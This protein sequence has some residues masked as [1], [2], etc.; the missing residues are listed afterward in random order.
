MDKV[1]GVIGGMGPL[2]A[3][4]LFE[5]IVLLTDAHC[6]QEH[7]HIIIDN[8]TTIP[9]RTDYI[10]GVIPDD[11]KEGLIDSAKKLQSIGADF[12]VICCNTAHYFYDDLVKSVD[13]PILSMIE[14]TAKYINENYN[15][16]SEVGL[17]STEGTSKLLIYD[18]VFK[19]YGIDIIKPT[20]D[21]QNY[22]TDIIY[23]IKKGIPTKDFSGF[24]ATMEEMKS[25][26]ANIFI[27]GC[28]ELPIAVE[29]Y[30][31]KGRFID[32]LEIIAI[33]SIKYSG[34]SVKI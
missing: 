27:T 13:I 34:K 12:L 4:K 28:T 22:I 29:L 8:N 7:L 24:Y 23:N 6:D 1:L 10:L 31:L 19:K 21:N 5:R 14:E 17:L 15:S 9:D 16:I 18:K 3:V 30:N 11:P 32:P 20:T 2:S 25:R 26:G 33:K